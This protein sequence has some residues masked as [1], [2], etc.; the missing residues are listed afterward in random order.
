M[1]RYVDTKVVYVGPSGKD[2]GTVAKQDGGGDTKIIYSDWVGDKSMM[3]D[4]SDLPGTPAVSHEM[5]IL[6]DDGTPDS[7]DAIDA[8]FDMV[9][10][11]IAPMRARHV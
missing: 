9:T 8:T 10:P 3:S 5:R 11:A 2:D 6:W 7:I 4:G 1:W